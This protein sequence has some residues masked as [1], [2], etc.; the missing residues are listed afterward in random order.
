MSTA[1]WCHYLQ[2]LEP[3]GHIAARPVAGPAPASIVSSSTK[4]QYSRNEIEACDGSTV[5]AAPTR[6]PF[7]HGTGP[8]AKQ[9]SVHGEHGSSVAHVRIASSF[10]NMQSSLGRAT[11]CIAQARLHC[12]VKTTWQGGAMSERDRDYTASIDITC[13]LNTQKC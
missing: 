1:S 4:T 8:S 10:A 12:E 6:L 3:Q 2:R 11:T 5:G 13:E 7:A 9:N